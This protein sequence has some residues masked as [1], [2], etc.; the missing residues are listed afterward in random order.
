MRIRAGKREAG[1]A[2]WHTLGGGA[3]PGLAGGPNPG[4]AGLGRKWLIRCGGGG[5]RVITKHFCT[6]TTLMLRQDKRLRDHGRRMGFGRCGFTVTQTSCWG[7]RSQRWRGG[8]RLGRLGREAEGGER[9][10]GG[11][12]AGQERGDGG[13]L[14]AVQG[15]DVDHV[16]QVAA[17]LGIEQVA[18]HRQLAVGLR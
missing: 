17:G 15:Q 13:D 11:L 10:G 18:R 2:F 3:R 7:V 4:V 16:G 9:R 6:Y 14:V 1:C 8:I 12:V 5:A